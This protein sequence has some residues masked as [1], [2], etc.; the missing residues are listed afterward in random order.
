MLSLKPT[1]K[2]VKEYF[3]EL[4]RIT[5]HGHVNE[6]TVRNAFQDLLQTLSKKVQ[7]QFIEEYAIKRKGRRDASV[8]GAL[9]DQFSLPRGFWEAKDTKDDLA[10]EVQNKFADG[11]PTSNILFWQPGRAILIQEGRQIMDADI[12]RPEALVDVLQTFFNFDLPYIKEWEHAVEEFKQRIPDLAESVL[13]V[14]EEQRGRNRAFRD[15][16]D[17]FMQLAKAS[18]NPDL[19][20]EAVEEMLIQHLLTRRIFRTIF[21]SEGFLQKNA[22]ARELE[23][24]VS[25]L[26]Q[27]YGTVDQFLKP[28]DRFYK[29]LE[30]AA[31]STDDYAQKQTFLNTVYEKFFQGF[32]V[33]VADTHGIVYTPQPIVDFMVRSVEAALNKDFGKS[34]ADEGVH[35][36]DP[37]VGT[38]NFI[39]RVMREIHDKRPQALRQ[40]YLHELHCNEVMLLP[41]YIACLNIEHLYME[42][43]GEY[44]PFPGICLVD[45]FELVE[46]RQIGMFT[47]ENNDRVQR[48]KD[49]PIFVV[50]GNPPY[51]AGQVNEN[52]NNKNRKYP[53]ID[54]RVQE[55]YVKDSTA[56]YRADL[57]DPYVKAFRMASDRVLSR[58][59]GIVCFVTNSGFIEGIA[60][61][62]MRKHLRQDFDRVSLID[63]GGN[64]RKNP[65]LTGTK[66]NVFGI[67]VGVAIAIMEHHANREDFAVNYARMDECWTRYQKYREL[68]RL[69]DYSSAPYVEVKANARHIWLTEG[70][71][72]DWERLL[73]LGSKSAT[74]SDAESL[75]ELYSLGVSTNRDTWTYGWS[76]AD[77]T[78]KM[79]DSIEYYNEHVV[80]RQLD[81][82]SDMDG[83]VRYVDT[84]ISWSE[85]LKRN[86]RSGRVA[87]YSLDSLRSSMYRPFSCRTLFFDR[88]FVDRL[89]KFPRIFPL[90]QTD[91][92]VV[93][94]SGIG[95]SKPFQALA[96]DS[97]PCLD[98]LEKTQCFP[99]HVFDTDGSNRR[100]NIT[101]WGLEQFRSHYNDTS[102]TK[103]DIF[104]YVYGILH[105]PGYRT[106]YAANL[107]RELP[108]IPFAADFRKVADIGKRLMDLHVNYE[109][110]PEYPLEEAWSLPKGYRSEYGNEVTSVDQVPLHERYRVVKMKRN[111]KDPTQIIV[112][113]FLTL[114]GIPA[115]VDDYKLGNRSALDWVIDQYQISTDKRSG[116]TNDP[117][118]EDDPTYI[119]RLIKK[120]VTVSVET[121]G[122][123][124]EMDGTLE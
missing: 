4:E 94:V 10:K 21:K 87:N 27:G 31:E 69:G 1:H 66:H 88:V 57:S 43:T 30:L 40:K 29:A 28:L 91:N 74:N 26:V 63:L 123:V 93:C 20:I 65:K 61:D 62:G 51:N 32:A 3:A 78:S 11:Y 105:D 7:W 113:D 77:V 101:D 13:K 104:H 97:I 39:L 2:P 59:E 100:E 116:I 98:I 23:G 41:Y 103:L 37:F 75:F 36:L 47:N 9:L 64:I 16:F 80:R 72:N 82:A 15:S 56:T 124:G 86:L 106:K 114:K 52:D 42:L 119:V 60:F 90:P 115:N 118:R 95:S 89:L 58:G 73:P 33:K 85:G 122:V 108:R 25:N 120:V 14:L 46:D 96:V 121:V 102:I 71:A 35:I 68:Q 24:V 76:V 109:D 38:G 99:L 107:K 54:K 83:F 44:L 8:D 111:K 45:T 34:L 79:K 112:N 48:Q 117:N 92:L 49:A 17:A 84:K 67:Q 12:S 55:T 5:G 19:S 70:M 81:A 18:I 6:M 22:V 50:I 110:Q 53:A